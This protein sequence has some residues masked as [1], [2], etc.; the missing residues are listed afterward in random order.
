[1]CSDEDGTSRFNCT[2]TSQYFGERCEMNRCNSNDCLNGGTCVIAVIDDIP[3]PRCECLVNFGGANCN[4]DLC[5][6][7]ECGNGTCIGGNCQC[8]TNYVNVNN[9][10]ELT[11]SS[12]PCQASNT[13]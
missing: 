4:L 1:M 3:T 11:C 10:C 5:L 2:C 8:D 12:S 6:G 7:I 9:N 13:F